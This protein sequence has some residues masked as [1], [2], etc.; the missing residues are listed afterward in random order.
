MKEE[1]TVPISRKQQ[2][3]LMG[4]KGCVATFFLSLPNKRESNTY[5]RS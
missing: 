3:V 4:S 5:N 1:G 2:E